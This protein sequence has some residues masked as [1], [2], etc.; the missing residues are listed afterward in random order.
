MSCRTEYDKASAQ[1]FI[2]LAKQIIASE[3]PPMRM[4][5]DP[6]YW[7]C[8]W[9]DH[10]AVCHLKTFPQ[11]TCRSCAHVTPMLDEPGGWHCRKWE[12]RIPVE[13]QRTGCDQH[14]YHPEILP[15]LTPV[16]GNMDENWVNY[17]DKKTG[18]TLTLSL[19]HI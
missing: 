10:H 18:E 8:K 1:H 13:T 3:G 4:S 5:E 9:C 6:A 19:I 2:D 7:Q 12:D 15:H 16:N 11:P 14:L 17:E